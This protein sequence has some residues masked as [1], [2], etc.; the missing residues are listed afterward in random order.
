MHYAVKFRK[1]EHIEILLKNGADINIQNS[2]G[3]TPLHEAVLSNDL[4]MVQF[5]LTHGARVIGSDNQGVTPLMHAPSREMTEILLKAPFGK[6]F[7]NQTSKEDRGGSALHYAVRRGDLEQVKL[8]FEN[9]ANPNALTMRRVSPL[10]VAFGWNRDWKIIEELIKNGASLTHKDQSGQ[11]V[12]FY[13]HTKEKLIKLLETDA[14]QF[15]NEEGDEGTVLHYR[16]ANGNLKLLRI[17]IKAGAD[18]NAV[19][20]EGVTPLTLAK[21]LGKKG[22]V[23][24][25][26]SHGAVD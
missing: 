3:R 18:V 5:L 13:A 14:R 4:E 19:N 1:L 8:L 25:L 23:K 22:F 7:I 16:V 6:S 10:Q 11:N 26:R 9:G 12:L 21:T 17:L 20:Q 2:K 24:E 15:I